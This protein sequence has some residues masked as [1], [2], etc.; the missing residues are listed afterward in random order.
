[1]SEAAFQYFHDV[2]ARFS[3]YKLDSELSAMNRGEIALETHSAREMSEVLGLA[4]L[5]RHETHGLFRYPPS[6]WA[7]RSVGSGQGLG[8]P[9]R[10][11][12]DRDRGLS[13]LLRRGRRRHPVPR[14]QRAGPALARR[15]PQSVRR[16]TRSSRC[17]CLAMLASR[18][19]ATMFAASH[20]YDPHAGASAPRRHRQPH[21]RRP[22]HLRGRQVR[23]GRLRHGPRRHRL[24]RGNDPASRGTPSTVTASPP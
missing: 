3:P 5:T 20:I 18:P 19:P 14:P 8:D 4:V 21:G 24:H 2:D 6:G 10:G 9:Q 17:W 15:H 12:A 22:R 13:Q 7:R 23:H 1:M 16:S 11:T